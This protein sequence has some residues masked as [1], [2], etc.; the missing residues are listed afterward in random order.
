MN[1]SELFWNASSE[2]IKK[3]YVQHNDKFTC[4]ICNQ[5]F[6]KGIIY[7]ENG[8]FYEAE[9]YTQVHIKQKHNSVFDF[10]I[11][12]DKKYT[13]LT[14]LQKELIEYFQKGISDQEIVKMK[15][16]SNASTIRNHR[17]TLREREKQAKVF[18]SIM[19]LMEEKMENNPKLVEIHSTA[20]MVDER[21]LM[22]EEENDKVIKTF[23]KNGL[24]GPII[25]FPKK[26]KQ[27]IAVIR[28]IMKKFDAEKI[29]SEKEVNVILKA[30]F[31]DH[32]TI[33]RYL[34]EYGFMDRTDDCNQYWVK[35]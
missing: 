35:K 10:L 33:R 31:D 30:F 5:S 15:V 13:G 7:P 14:D 19:E 29:Y 11:N 16:G 24:D 22:T 28:Q 23:F 2:E 26:E 27:K 8:L 9:K 17:F 6:E 20:T 34:I 1:I 4:L 25:R 32:V 12:M 3:G 18:L 21:Y